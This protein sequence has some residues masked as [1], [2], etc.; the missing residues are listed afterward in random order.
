M[1]LCLR[2]HLD[3]VLVKLD[4]SIQLS[5]YLVA[6][7]L[8]PEFRR[9]SQSRSFFHCSSSWLPGTYAL[10]ADIGR[11]CS[12]NAAANRCRG[13]HIPSV[14]GSESMSELSMSDGRP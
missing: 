6:V 10:E 9:S 1:G 4:R 3:R 11:L 13:F 7:G 2:I 12:P 8:P 14:E 5:L